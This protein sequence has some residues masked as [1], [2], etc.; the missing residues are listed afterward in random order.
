M[1]ATKQIRDL[2]GIAAM[3]NDGLDF[4]I[5]ISSLREALREHALQQ[6]TLQARK[7]LDIAAEKGKPKD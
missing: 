3:A 5:A 6:F 1:D 2:C 4:E 7:A